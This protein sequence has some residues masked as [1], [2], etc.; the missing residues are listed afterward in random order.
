[1]CLAQ[2]PQC[3]DASEARTRGPSV[4]SQAFYH[5][6]TALPHL[7]ETVCF[8][9]STTYVLVKK[10]FFLSTGLK[11]DQSILPI[12]RCHPWNGHV[13]WTPTH[14]SEHG[15]HTCAAVQPA[16]ILTQQSSFYVVTNQSRL[17][18]LTNQSRLHILTKQSRLHILT[19]QSRLH[20]LTNQSRLHILTNQSHLHILTI[21]VKS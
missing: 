19:N 10:Y 18:I 7:I 6:A 12:L 9:L 17:H 21:T 8:L 1:M 14:K 2:R 16:E 15:A 11:S 3:S 13:S 5:W 20:I 4:S